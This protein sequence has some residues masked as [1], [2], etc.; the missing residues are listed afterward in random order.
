[1]DPENEGPSEDTLRRL[2]SDRSQVLRAGDILGLFHETPAAFFE[3]LAGPSTE[4]DTEKIEALL[5]KRSQARDNKDWAASDAIRDQLKDM[6]VILEDGP[7]GT[8]WRL[9]V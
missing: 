7:Q 2:K 8:A 1:M 9:D 4:V 5:Q 6:G 3:Q